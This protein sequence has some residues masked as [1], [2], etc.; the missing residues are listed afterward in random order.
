MGSGNY[1]EKLSDWRVLE[2]VKEGSQSTHIEMTTQV[3]LSV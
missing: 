2:Q 1:Y 3:G